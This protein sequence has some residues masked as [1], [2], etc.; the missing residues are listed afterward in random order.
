MV[1]LLSLQEDLLG[2]F[3]VHMTESQLN[4]G[5]AKEPWALLGGPESCDISFLGLL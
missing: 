2:H 4:V 3:Q 1:R 5:E